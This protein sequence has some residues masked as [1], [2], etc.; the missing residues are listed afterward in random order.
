MVSGK[1]STSSKLCRIVDDSS[2]FPATQLDID[3][4]LLLDCLGDPVDIPMGGS[5][6]LLE[7]FIHAGSNFNLSDPV[8]CE[9]L[10][11]IDADEWSS[12]DEIE[13]AKKR[14]EA[15]VLQSNRL[16]NE[17][18]GRVE[19]NLAAHSAFTLSLL[20]RLCNAINEAG[21]L[22]ISEERVQNIIEKKQHNSQILMLNDRITKLSLDII[23][24]NTKHRVVENEKRKVEKRLDKL[25]C[26]NAE[27]EQ[28]RA[29]AL[30]N[31]DVTK[32]SDELANADGVAIDETGGG[33][34]SGVAGGGAKI[35]AS[36]EKELKRQIAVLERQLAE[37]E[38]AK[39]H[40]EMLLTER[41]A[42]PLAQTEVQVAD[43]RR[44]MEELRQQ[45][46]QRVS[47]LL[48]EV[49]NLLC[50]LL[51]VLVFVFDLFWVFLAYL[52]YLLE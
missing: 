10:P 33:L 28:R 47:Q 16:D 9:K 32:P 39:S 11:K 37:S 48:A 22:T 41:L 8:N 36:V 4:S 1:F 12:S 26:A 27:A 25:L 44:A 31:G 13:A 20:E 34:G 35:D 42:R 23:N 49:F 15:M 46:K 3:S 45:C 17:F 21:A 50:T 19:E 30:E 6:E 43:M 29:Q 14:A 40:G 5:T 51:S 18:G 2:F 7:R 52:H 38:S 24:L